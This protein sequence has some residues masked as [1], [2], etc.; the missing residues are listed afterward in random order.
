M[1]KDENANPKNWQR[2]RILSLSDLLSSGL[3]SRSNQESITL[4]PKLQPNLANEDFRNQAFFYS[5]LF[6]WTQND[7]SRFEMA[8]LQ[9]SEQK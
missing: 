2:R 3:A 1:G 8:D 5:L 6:R 9:E 4:S 7:G